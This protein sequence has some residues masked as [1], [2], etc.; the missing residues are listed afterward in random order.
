M[1][2]IEISRRAFL[3]ATS[4]TLGA[5][6]LTSCGVQPASPF[7]PAPQTGL[8]PNS[9]GLKASQGFQA[10]LANSRLVVGPNRFALGLVENGSSVKD[11]TV[12]LKFF[13]LNSSQ[14]VLKSE[15]DAVYYGDNLGE[16]GVY[17][18][19][20][21]FDAAGTWGVAVA[22]QSPGQP[23]KNSN[24]SFAVLE[25]DTIPNVGE[26]APR[27]KNLT[28]ADVGGDRTKIC[29]AVEEDRELHTLS[30][31]DALANGKPTVVLFATP[32]YCTSRTCGPSLQVVQALAKNY[33]GKVNFIHIE[34][35]KNFQTFELADTVTEW[36]LESEPW[37]FFVGADGK[38]AARFEG[39]IT[40]K[41]IVPAFL[42]FAGQ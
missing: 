38:I 14:G 13:N 6:V 17:V 22:A 19:H 21:T 39:G 11:A 34:I 36:K 1:N 26:A 12:N 20:V 31:A 27:S 23:A 16:A 35:Y 3:R 4:L 25:H 29:S 2:Q 18:G 8:T 42:K 15:T 24:I 28:L 32:A 40:S 37:L 9:G 10:I 7:T 30:I 41:E 5:F 33:L